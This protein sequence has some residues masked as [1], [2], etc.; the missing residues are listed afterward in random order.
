LALR[1]SSPKSESEKAASRDAAQKDVFLREV[2]DALRQDQMLSAL[3]RYGKPVGALIVAALIGL[4]GFL[5]WDHNRSRQMGEQGEKLVMALDRIEAGHP[6]SAG[7]E[8]DGVV[9]GGGGAAIAAQML[10][11]GI[12][13]QQGRT[14]EAVTAFWRVADDKDAPAPLR[15]L[16][17]IRQVALGFDAMQPQQ[18]VDRLKPL[19]VPGNPWFGSAGELV[20]MAY[21]KQGR[22]DLAGPLFASLSRDKD[23]PESLRRRA[24]QMAGLLGVDAID[25]AAKAAAGNSAGDG[26]DLDETSPAGDSAP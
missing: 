26:A 17:T 12:A 19:A 9:E 25:D 24:R 1:P 3:R 10:Q 7:K 2:D 18:V 4:G 14:S 15:D 13:A 11:A 21:L 8:L 23:V 22:G 5:L 16:A 20:G 6:D